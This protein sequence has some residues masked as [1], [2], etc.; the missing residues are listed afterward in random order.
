MREYLGIPFAELGRTRDG[1][2]CLGLVMLVYRERL[3]IALPEPG[4]ETTTDR[5]IPRLVES[6]LP[7][8]S[9]VDRPRQYDVALF[10][11]QIWHVGVMIDGVRMLHVARGCDSSIDRLDPLWLPRLAGFYRYAG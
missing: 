11:G 1:C 3:G 2:D 8:W 5:A 4:Y 10:R 7:A 9:P 6:H